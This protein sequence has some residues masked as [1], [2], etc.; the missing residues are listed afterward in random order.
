MKWMRYS[1]RKIYRSGQFA[2]LVA[3]LLNNLINYKI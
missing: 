2:I 3:V 1:G